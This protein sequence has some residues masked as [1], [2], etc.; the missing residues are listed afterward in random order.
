MADLVALC[1]TS[2]ETT[3]FSGNTLLN[4]ANEPYQLL[5]AQAAAGQPDF[6]AISTEVGICS[7]DFTEITLGAGKSLACSISDFSLIT[8]FEMLDNLSTGTSA[9]GGMTEVMFSQLWLLI[10]VCGLLVTFGLGA[11]KGG[12]R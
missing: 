8:R 3:T 4:C 5:T 2:W 12:Q 9:G 7:S 6:T 11:I 1:S 10:F